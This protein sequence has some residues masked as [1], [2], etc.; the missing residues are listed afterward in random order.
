LN[1][2][3]E[4][5]VEV[6]FEFYLISYSPFLDTLAK[7]KLDEPQEHD[8][9]RLSMG[10]KS[11]S[12]K[13]NLTNQTEQAHTFVEQT[14]QM[15]LDFVW[16]SALRLLQL[17]EEAVHYTCPSLIFDRFSL[18]PECDKFS[19]IGEWLTP[20]G[21]ILS[22]LLYRIPIGFSIFLIVSFK[23][24]KNSKRKLA[25]IARSQSMCHF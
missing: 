21:S 4:L 2:E 22:E 13:V 25:R 6:V 14:L 1:Q 7:S 8:Q 11:E 5:I 12:K 19:F 3:K 18:C 10:S 15:D 16:I 20:K 24:R 9:S 23:K 17:F